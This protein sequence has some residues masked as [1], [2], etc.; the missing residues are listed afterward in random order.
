MSV[1]LKAVLLA[2]AALA[3]GLVSLYLLSRL[4]L[5]PSYSALE[6]RFVRTNV[7]QGIG[8]LETRL[9]SLSTTNND[10]SAWDDT[11]EFVETR[12]D[13]YIATNLLDSTFTTIGLHLMVFIDADGTVVYAKAMDAA[14]EHEIDMPEDLSTHLSPGSLLLTHDDV[15]SSVAGILGLAQGPMLVSS[16]PIVTSSDEGPIRGTLLMGSRIDDDFVEEMAAT[17]RLPLSLTSTAVSQPM[18]L[19]ADEEPGA[20]AAD[21]EVVPVTGD[22][23]EGQAKLLDIY[24]QPVAE[25][26]ISQDRSI[27]AEGQHTLGYFLGVVM[28]GGVLLVLLVLLLL[29]RTVLRRIARLASE[30]Q[31]CGEAQDFSGRVSSTGNDEI[32][33]LARSINDTLNALAQTHAKLQSSHS[34]LEQTTMDLKR[35]EQEL[36]TTANQLRRLTRHLQSVREEERALVASEM[37]D[38]IGQAL[39]TLRMDMATLAKT[40]A[41]GA[42]PTGSMLDEMSKVVDSLMETVKRM[43]VGLYPSILGDL[44]LGEAMEWQLAEFGRQKGIHTS[45]S[46]RGDASTVDSSRA[47]V[48][49]RIL[50]ESLA[51]MAGH[52]AATDV[53]VTLTI[54]SLYALLSIADNGKPLSVDD[55]QSGRAI[56]LGLIKERAEV[57]GGGV[58]ITSD[59]SGTA[60]VTQLPL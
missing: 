22:I 36:R 17:T 45:L 55:P 38:R 20:L 3:I 9:N 5:A 60:I 56:A 23:V 15:R 4:V 27:Y 30:V 19:P 35:T 46:V 50:Q 40:S 53:A 21:I 48:L 6:E 31:A 51:E 12:S 42:I 39:T 43:S 24:G 7:E 29:D 16:R 11:Y 52:S 2:A 34:D 32:G 44:G 37:H 13:A 1:R 18:P 41:R 33:T 8:A 47:L 58:T 54:E 25:L 57:L 59:E 10:W 49:F 26:T 14:I 28:L